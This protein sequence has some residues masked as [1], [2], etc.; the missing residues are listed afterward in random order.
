[1]P[2]PATPGASLE[3]DRGGAHRDSGL[4]STTWLPTTPTMRSSSW[5]K[6]EDAKLLAGGHSLLPAMKLRLARPALVVDIGRMGDLSDVFGEDWRQDRDRCADA[7]Q[8]RRRWR[9]SFGENCPIVSSHRRP[10]RRPASTA[11]G[12]DRWFDRAR[13]SRIRP[14]VGDPRTRSRSWSPAGRGGERTIACTGLLHR[15]LPDSSSAGRNAR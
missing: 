6:R 3:G 7:T 10:G 15:R 5:G 12:N 8:G 2:L 13:R 14:P 4:R 1:M 9:L 11:P